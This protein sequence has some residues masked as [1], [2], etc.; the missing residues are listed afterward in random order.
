MNSEYILGN[1]IAETLKKNPQLVKINK[2][3]QD[4]YNK[5]YLYDFSL[6]DEHVT[7]SAA[8]TDI[9][10]QCM[11]YV[12]VSNKI[13]YIFKSSDVFTSFEYYLGNLYFQPTIVY[14]NSKNKRVYV[15]MK[16]IKIEHLVFEERTCIYDEYKVTTE[17]NEQIAYNNES[18]DCEV[19]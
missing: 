11:K 2:E 13:A 4:K 6:L 15:I 8:L 14:S 1:T 16:L 18:I 12:S 5:N 19:A 9:K 17:I 7:D 3:F 10:N